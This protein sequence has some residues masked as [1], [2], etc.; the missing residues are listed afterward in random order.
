MKGPSLNAFI[1]PPQR[2]PIFLKL[3]LW[4]TKRIV[5]KE[6]LLPKLLAWY[7]KA[8]L[9]SG[10]LESLIAHHE[11][12]VTERL[13]KLVRMQTSYTV[14]CP[15]CVDMNSVEAERFQI[16]DEEIT[17]LQGQLPIESVS[18]LTSRERLALAYVRSV[19]STPIFVPPELMAELKIQFT[20]REIVVLATTIAQVNYWTRLAQ[21]LGVPPAGF[22]KYCELPLNAPR[23][24]V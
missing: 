24:T 7:P 11:G 16:T 10:M 9:S 4:V 1:S 2:V 15:F 21:A 18:S 14:A 5:G 3:G 8:A 13:L 20:E 17:V 12:N 19:C 6:L 22:T 23:Q